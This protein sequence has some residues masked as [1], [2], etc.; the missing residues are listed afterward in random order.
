[1][2]RGFSDLPVLCHHHTSHSRACHCLKGNHKPVHS[3]P[4][5]LPPPARGPTS[6]DLSGFSS[7]YPSCTWTC[8]ACFCFAECPRS[9]LSMGACVHHP[10]LLG[11]ILCVRSLVSRHLGCF[12]LL[13]T[14]HLCDVFSERAFGSLWHIAT[15]PR[16]CVIPLGHILCFPSL[17]T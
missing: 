14:E 8:A 10:C 6:L 17:G 13:L 2:N 1:M 12:N 11:H 3:H 16:L 15:I 4:R 5:H 7:F 9:F